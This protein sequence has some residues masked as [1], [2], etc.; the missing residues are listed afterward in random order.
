MIIL[1]R[2]SPSIGTDRSCLFFGVGWGG[3]GE[4]GRYLQ[5]VNARQQ[6]SPELAVF[7]GR[8]AN[9]SRFHFNGRSLD[10]IAIFVDHK[11]MNASVSLGQ[12]LDQGLKKHI[13][14]R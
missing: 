5:L 4:S 9:V 12:E 14:A 8:E 7:G 3:V 6:D 1:K 13:G 10:G 11:A 2:V